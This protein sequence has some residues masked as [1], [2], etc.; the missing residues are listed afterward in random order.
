MHIL[1]RLVEVMAS[2]SSLTPF[3]SSPSWF[4]RVTTRMISSSER[5][6]YSGTRMKLETLI[7]TDRCPTC[8]TL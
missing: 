5:M 4:T 3:F 1:K 8:I 6:S 7:S 2:L